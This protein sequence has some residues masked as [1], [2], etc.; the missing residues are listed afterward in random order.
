MIPEDK[1][2]IDGCLAEGVL[3]EAGE[4]TC[5]RHRPTMCQSRHPNKPAIKCWH[6]VGHRG[7]HNYLALAWT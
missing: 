1:C 5:P 4:R 2:A 6:G 7:D 3:D